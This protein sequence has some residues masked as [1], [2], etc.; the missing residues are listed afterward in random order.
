MDNETLCADICGARCCRGP[1][2]LDDGTLLLPVN[3]R[4][5]NLDERNRCRIYETRP[6]VC[7]RFPADFQLVDGCALSALLR[8]PTLRV[9]RV[10]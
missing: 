10:E 3:G 4:C 2:M 9:V 7:R 1:I 8:P 5:P 6:Q